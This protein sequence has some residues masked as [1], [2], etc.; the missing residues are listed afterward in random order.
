MILTVK[1]Q[2]GFFSCLDDTGLKKDILNNK[3]VLVK[4]I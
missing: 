3:S 2:T 1:K 4:L